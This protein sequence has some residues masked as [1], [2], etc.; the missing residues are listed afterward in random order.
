METPPPPPLYDQI[1]LVFMLMMGT[2]VGHLVEVRW[3]PKQQ[4]QQPPQQSPQQSLPQ[5]PP[6]QEPHQGTDNM[7]W[8]I[9]GGDRRRE[10]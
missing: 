4:Q 10:R 6:Q 8:R 7:V 1:Q 3:G 2:E 5:K 9:Y